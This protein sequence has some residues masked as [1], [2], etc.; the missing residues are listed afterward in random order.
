M[1]IEP[2][3]V[4]LNED[5]TLETLAHGQVHGACH[6]GRQWHGD[7]LA[8]LADHGESAVA[9]LEPDRVDV[10][11]DRLGHSETVQCQ[12]RDQ[13]MVSRRGQSGGDEDRTEFVA[14]E[15]SDVDS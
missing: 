1:P 15:M 4:G 13:R 7:D 2:A 11:T 10:G 3:A 8:P 12:Q 6:S 14:V 5:P 9:A